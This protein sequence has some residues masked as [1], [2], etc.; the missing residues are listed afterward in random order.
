[1]NDDQFIIKAAALS[2]A[3]PN[4][5]RGFVEEFKRYVD[6]R[7]DEC[8]RAPAD[9][10]FVAQGRAQQCDVLFGQLDTC[11]SVADRIAEKGKR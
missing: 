3:A 9:M 7:R 6:R 2:R 1:M 4:E 11:R 8:V 5:W 10:V